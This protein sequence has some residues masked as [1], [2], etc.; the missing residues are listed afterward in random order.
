M[1]VLVRIYEV[2]NYNVY[3]KIVN[4]YIVSI[5]NVNKN[6]ILIKFTIIVNY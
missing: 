5:E 3:V 4:N 1:F 2:N 6:N